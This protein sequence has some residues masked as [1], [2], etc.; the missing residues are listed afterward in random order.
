MSTSIANSFARLFEREVHINFQQRTSYL[1]GTTRKRTITG[2]ESTTFQ[3]MGSG[4]AVQKARHGEVPPMNIDHNPVTIAHAPWYAKEYVDELDTYFIQHDE[5]AALVQIASFALGRRT[6]LIISGAMNLTTNVNGDGTV[7]MTYQRALAI[8]EYFGDKSIPGSDR[9]VAVGWHQWAELLT[10]DAFVNSDYVGPQT[11][12]PQITMPHAKWWL[13]FW[14]YPM[15]NLPKSGTTRSCFAYQKN[16][17]GHVTSKE[18]STDV[19]WNGE[20]Q[21]WVITTSMSMGA[22]IIE[23][24]GVMKVLC[25][26]DTTLNAL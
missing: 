14:W 21:A 25:K 1:N 6:D 20:K 2:A 16:A 24:V 5:R 12:G 10:I 15:E 23:D 26:D 7:G 19:W 18:P 17:I 3:R 4:E 8:M 22:K 11:G 9:Y 13:G